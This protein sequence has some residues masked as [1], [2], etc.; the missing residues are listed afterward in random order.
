[1]A[2]PGSE[3]RVT[4]ANQWE[5]STTAEVLTKRRKKVFD[6][7]KIIQLLAFSKARSILIIKDTCNFIFTCY[8]TKI[9]F[10]AHAWH[11]V[12]YSYMGE[13]IV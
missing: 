7:S 9:I 13:L 1:M 3:Q 8:T 5:G 10:V 4:I 11:S 6:F 12:L 2:S